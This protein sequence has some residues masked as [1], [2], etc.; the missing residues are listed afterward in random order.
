MNASKLRKIRRRPK[1]TSRLPS[2]NLR[3]S[4]KRSGKLRK[5]LPVSQKMLLH[6]HFTKLPS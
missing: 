6:R 3:P 2:R 4:T 1:M 5:K